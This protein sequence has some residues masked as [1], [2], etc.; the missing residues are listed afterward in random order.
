MAS[1]R[2]LSPVS[3]VIVGVRFAVKSLE[4][5]LMRRSAIDQGIIMG[6]SFL[7]G[8]VTGATAG[9]AAGLLPIP[10]SGPATRILGMVAA[11]ARSAQA[12]NARDRS[13]HPPIDESEAWAEIGTEV[14]SALALVG[15]ASRKGRAPI[16][17]PSTFSAVGAG[18]L[19]E[20]QAALAHRQDSPDLAYLGK[21]A[22]VAVGLNVGL[23]GIGGAILTGGK[24]AA[25]AA[26]RSRIAPG[27]AFVGGVALT[28]VSLGVCGRVALGTLLGKIAAG[29]R[30]TEIAFAQAPTADS[31][32]GSRYSLAGY[33]TLGL[34]GRRLVS[35]TTTV[36][37]IEAEMGESAR[38]APVRVYVGLGTADTEDERIEIALQELKRAGGFDRSLIIAASPAGTGYVN[39][40]AV[41][42]A[43]FMARGD[44]ATV[45]VQYGEVPSIL[46]ITKVSDAARVYGKLVARL[47][48]EIS[49]IGRNIRLA[50]YGESL[51]AIT[52][53]MGV[54]QAS[55]D[56]GRLIVDFALWVGTP[57]GSRLFTELTD[58]GTPVF[59]QADGLHEWLEAGHAL[60]ETVLLNHDNDPVT[61]FTPKVFYEM[62][63][64]LKTHDRGRNVDARMRWLPGIS[65][66]Q[67]LIDTKNAATVI[68][69]EF[70]S[71]GH[72]YR[73][74]LAEFVRAAYRFDDV[75]PAQMEAIEARLRR[76]EITRAERIAEGRVGSAPVD[77]DQIGSTP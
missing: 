77:A 21:A 33:D 56:E 70:Y 59:D 62:P 17:N 5:S 27:V 26:R 65:F 6:G 68:P 51:G 58:G 19:F 10:R 46:S 30:K 61:K 9:A 12:L 47:R 3:G 1:A 71:T 75:S 4:P 54:Q 63:N 29:N 28:V 38:R 36:E 20:A 76:S 45:G 66:W 67:L 37:D 34:Q 25:F 69:G 31:V 64:W 24:V 42:A 73:A 57:K 74:D 18:T 16:A 8:F 11:S 40:I 44:V 60:P 14:V 7:T 48:S 50:S 15:F 23:A 41:E 13:S 22:S 55:K 72:D 49:E 35:E 2:F 32:S 52:A 39:Y 43:E 53:Q